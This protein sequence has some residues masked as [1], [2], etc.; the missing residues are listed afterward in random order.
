MREPSFAGAEEVWMRFIVDVVGGGDGDGDGGEMRR[1]SSG[2]SVG[3]APQG[4]EIAAAP[5]CLSSFAPLTSISSYGP[6]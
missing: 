1:R 2:L 3:R 4:E 6:S 5:A